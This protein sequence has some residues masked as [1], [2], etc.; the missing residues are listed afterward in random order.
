M[1]LGPFIVFLSSKYVFAQG[2]DT[3]GSITTTNGV[4]AGSIFWNYVWNGET[5]HNKFELMAGKAEDNGEDVQ[6]IVAI[7]LS[8]DD[9][10]SFTYTLHSGMLPGSYHVR[11]NGTIWNGST[12]LSTKPT[13]RSDT[14][15]Y[16]LPDDPLQ[17]VCQTTTW[18]PVRSVTD[19]GYS[20]L[21]VTSP[22]GGTLVVPGK[23]GQNIVGEIVK[24]DVTFDIGNMVQM[25]EMV[26]TQT[27]Y[28]AG[29]QTV[30]PSFWDDV[31]VPDLV[32][33]TSHLTLDPGSWKLRTN[34]TSNSTHNPGSFVA[35]SDE[36]FIV[37]ANETTC[38]ANSI[39]SASAA[40]STST[41]SGMVGKSA[42]G[43]LNI[44]MLAC[45]LVTAA[46]VAML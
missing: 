8:S 19:P 17:T 20:P 12:Q 21:R 9:A 37:L 4:D 2:D 32:Y 18:T 15:V 30:K 46:T 11:M 40:D 16:T 14:F 22:V 38:A 33:D 26:N 25:V 35:Y 23:D 44:P 42:E 39:S 10:R 24:V 43:K 41:P 29:A 6:D 34:F 31:D 5:G 27:G 28:S 3:I 7:G 45:A 1:L 36:F 13:T